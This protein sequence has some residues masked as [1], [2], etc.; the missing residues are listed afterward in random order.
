L[1]HHYT[2][3]AVISV[4]SSGQV[5]I[6]DDCRREIGKPYNY[7]RVINASWHHDQVFTKIGNDGMMFE[8]GDIKLADLL[9]K[10]GLVVE[11]QKPVRVDSLHKRSV[12]VLAQQTTTREG[13]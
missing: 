10:P 5:T 1:E 7:N 13:K 9:D 8:S 11:F 12:F 4:D 2:K 3:L 6:V